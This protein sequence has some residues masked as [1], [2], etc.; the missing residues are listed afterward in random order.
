ME[1]QLRSTSVIR[2]IDGIQMRMWQGVTRSGVPIMAMVARIAVKL[3][4]DQTEF[5]AELSETCPPTV[6]GDTFYDFRTLI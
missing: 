6:S 3:E 4:E 1:I 2:E 5:L